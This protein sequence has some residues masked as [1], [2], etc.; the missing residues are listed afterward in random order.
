MLIDNIEPLFKNFNADAE[1]SII[2]VLDETRNRG[3]SYRNADMLRSMITR[4][5]FVIK[6]KG[7]YNILHLIIIMIM[8]LYRIMIG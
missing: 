1:T 8:Y 2:T 5:T 7:I 3:G 4:K 6:P